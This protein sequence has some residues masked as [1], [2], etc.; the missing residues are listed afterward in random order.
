[1][2]NEQGERALGGAHS[3]LGLTIA[4][5][6]SIVYDTLQKAGFSKQDAMIDG[7]YLMRYAIGLLNS[8]L[9]GHRDCMLDLAQAERL[10]TAVQ[11]RLQHQSVALITGQKSFWDRIFYVD[12]HVLVPR[13]ET[14]TLVDLA[15]SEPFERVLDLGTGSG[16]ILV[17]LLALRSAATGHGID[18]SEPA[19]AVAR[20]NALHHAVAERAELYLSDW[21]G[22]INAQFDLIVAN[23]P[24]VTATEWL[25]LADDSRVFEPRVALVPENA[26]H[27]DDGLACYRTIVQDLPRYLLHGGRILLEAAAW[28]TDAVAAL[29]A[30]AGLD[31]ICIH[32]DLNGHKRVVAARWT[33]C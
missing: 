23:P 26:L 13:P 30:A 9:V 22:C 16:C 7:R 25:D 2:T 18:I 17:T 5:A 19:L 12:R 3:M 28:Q 8:G 15:L 21:F 11:A 4:A 20:Q 32:N 14:E 31:D 6:S 24:Y 27:A 1:M 29:V 10:C 33:G